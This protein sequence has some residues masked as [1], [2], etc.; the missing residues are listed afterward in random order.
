MYFFN[1]F[2]TLM[3]HPY[4]LTFNDGFRKN[5]TKSVTLTFS[6]LCSTVPSYFLT[7]CEGLYVNPD[8]FILIIPRLHA[9]IYFISVLTTMS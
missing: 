4:A 6:K 8:A 2:C 9:E 5:L 7:L 3:F 1:A